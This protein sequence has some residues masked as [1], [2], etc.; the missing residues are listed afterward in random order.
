MKNYK[1]KLIEDAVLDNQFI[2]L[3]QIL[4]IDHKES[5]QE[6]CDS[7]KDVCWDEE[8]KAIFETNDVKIRTLNIN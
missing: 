1:K 8:T 4:L 3:S 5:R 6:L 2:H 7:L